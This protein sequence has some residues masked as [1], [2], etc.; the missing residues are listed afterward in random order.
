MRGRCAAYPV[1]IRWGRAGAEARCEGARGI[2]RRE[3]SVGG[4]LRDMRVEKG[5]ELGAEVEFVRGVGVRDEGV[6]EDVG[7][8]FRK[9][10]VDFRKGWGGRW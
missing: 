9:G 4:D 3:E 6:S 7:D 2:L 5:E 10:T 1:E 8:E